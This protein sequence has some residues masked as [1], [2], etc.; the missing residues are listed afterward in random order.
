[1]LR[2]LSSGPYPSKLLEIEDARNK[3]ESKEQVKEVRMMTTKVVESERTAIGQKVTH[4]PVGLRL[5]IGRRAGAK[6]LEHAA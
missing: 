5:R 1:M 6:S 4:Q 3:N 2:A